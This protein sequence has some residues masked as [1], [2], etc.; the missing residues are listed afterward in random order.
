MSRPA[1][2]LAA[3]GSRIEPQVNE[4]IRDYARQVAACG[5]FNRV[6]AAFHHGQP[7]FAS[8]LD[9][10][11]ADEVVVVPVMTSVGYFS[12]VVL[13]REL[14]KNRR[15]PMM[16]LHQTQPIGTHPGM[17][18]LVAK[19]LRELLGD[20]H[21][22][23]S[24]TTVA[25]V[26]HGTERHRRS[27]LSTVALADALEQHGPCREVLPAFLDEDPVVES[28]RDRATHP[29][30]I[31]IPFLIG[32]GPHAAKDI[33]RQLG[34][35]TAVGQYP[36]LHGQLG[37]RFVVCDAPIGLQP[38]IVSIITELAR[39]TKAT[40]NRTRVHRG[41]ILRLGTR[42]SALALWQA[43]RVVELLAATGVSVE[44]VEIT[45]SGDRMIERA[46]EDL[47][48]PS[49]FTDDI[50][51]A[52]LSG[53][54]DLAVHS[55]KDLPVS[56]TSGLT[57]AAVLPRGEATEALVSRDHCKLRELPPGARIGTSSPRRRAQLLALRPD[58]CPVPIRGPVDDRV[59]QVREG[60]FDAAILATAGLE[61][62]ELLDEIA[63]RF[64][65]D[66][67]L[68]APAQGALVIQVR[69][70]D[71]TT[72]HQVAALNHEPTRR[73][74]T[75]ELE[76]LRIFEDVSDWVLAAH[77]IDGDHLTLRARLMS[78]D[79][80]GV[81]DVRVV[82]DNPREAAREAAARLEKML[83]VHSGSVR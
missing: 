28:I 44:I 29:N 48:S 68:P 82:A 11:E 71:P 18:L 79:G 49:P 19:R 76:L 33:P 27:R 41:N 6:I 50:E 57:L 77:A 60:K 67:F 73:A 38:G 7:S 51:Q 53:H 74:V 26:G 63:E 15:F 13:P 35:Q 8:V 54:I 62:L 81:H 39:S 80:T 10:L 36:P 52:L 21:L 55:W 69:E 3:H 70:D 45:T 4:G 40:S 43:Q 1:L 30:I 14:A 65:L 59:R 66:D 46:I 25:L 78:L 75:A 22:D 61:R 23:P 12:D 20:Y 17:T 56:G 2:I 83:G 24:A 47:P 31:V 72:A 64:T 9:E 42:R 37:G 58:L 34:L 32:A 5:L 16:R